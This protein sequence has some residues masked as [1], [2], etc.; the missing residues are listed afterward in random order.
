MDKYEELKLLFSKIDEYFDDAKDDY[1]ESYRAWLKIILNNESNIAKSEMPK[2]GVLKPQV[3]DFL[4]KNNL[5][6]PTSSNIHIRSGIINGPKANRH[7]NKNKNAL[8]DDEWEN[9]PADLTKPLNIYYDKK[10]N[11]IIYI[12]KSEVHRGSQFTVEIDYRGLK[13]LG[14]NMIVSAYKQKLFHIDERVNYGDFIK[15]M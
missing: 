8:S 7:K 9:L 11:H 15:I 1:A 5:R 13:E 6:M 2:V 10:S 3:L 14:G 12:V 4:R